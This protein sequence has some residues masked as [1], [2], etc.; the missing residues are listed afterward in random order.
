MDAANRRPQLPALA[1]LDVEKGQRDDDAYQTRNSGPPHSLPSV[2]TAS[3]TYAYPSGQPPPYS[4]VPPSSHPTNKCSGPPSGVHTPPGSRRSSGEEPDAKQATRQSLPSISEALGVDSQTSYQTSTSVSHAPPGS[5][6]PIA[7]PL[8][9]SMSPGSAAKRSYGVEHPT[10]SASSYTPN[11]SYSAPPSFRHELGPHQSY[12]HE[13]SRSTYASDRP[14][15][16][17]QTSEQGARPP[18]PPPPPP[19]TTQSSTYSYPSHPSSGYET[20]SHSANSMVPP[21]F[22][23]GYTPYPPRYVEH[24][25]S[26]VPGPI[27][28]PSA[29]HPA[30]STPWRPS[31]GAR[32][33]QDDRARGPSDYNGAIK[34]HLELYDLEGALNDISQTSNIMLDFSRRY[35]DRLHQTARNGP[36]SG[37]L[38]GLVEVDDMMNKSRLQTEALMKIREIVLAQQAAW[39]QQIA[40]QRHQKLYSDQPPHRDHV[41]DPDEGKAGF[42]GGDNKKRRGR[43]APP[44]RCHS[45]NRA[46]TPEWRRGPDG[47]R[48]L[49]NAC[50]LHYAKL[51]RKQQGVNKNTNVG[52]SNLR[53][54]ES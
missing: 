21:S 47:A 10:A 13:T 14:P 20:A 22:P 25:P 23:Y 30:P 11:G 43:A 35:G 27:Y 12:S 18:P 54:K 38:P 19:P 7:T 4:Q 52:S 39:E 50:G 46:E 36:I 16:H 24:T 33:G 37:T 32:Y 15:L 3:P 8:S 26:S 53:P 28:Q 6:N 49:C 40:D 42:A 48:T 31:D 44:G 1:Y 9:A 5:A 34:R 17:L 29:N 45:C 41:P 2:T 51:T